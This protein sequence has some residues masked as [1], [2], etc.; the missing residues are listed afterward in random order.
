MC[1]FNASE[2]L[3]ENV[4]YEV[5]KILIFYMTACIRKSNTNM[6]EIMSSFYDIIEILSNQ[7]NP[8]CYECDES[9]PLTLKDNV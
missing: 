4:F 1:F 8:Y 6:S 9:M 2:G 7:M 5:I 3:K